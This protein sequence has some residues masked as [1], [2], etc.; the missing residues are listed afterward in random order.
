M[1]RIIFPSR[2]AFPFEQVLA[3]LN[4]NYNRAIYYF[5]NV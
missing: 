4:K 1:R 2:F 5:L 3:V